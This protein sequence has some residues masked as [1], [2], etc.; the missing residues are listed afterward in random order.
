MGEVK[1]YEREKL[2]M[3]IMY[4]DRRMYDRAAETLCGI[5]GIIDCTSEEYSFSEFS[6]FYDI[7][8]NGDVM[9]RFVSFE[10]PVDPSLI[11]DIKIQTNSI[12]RDFSHEGRRRVNLD[13]CMLSHG[14][15][16]MATTK[17]ASFRIPLKGGI[18]ADLS[19][20]YSRGDWV[21]FFW[22]YFDVKSNKVKKFLKKARNIY[23]EQRKNGFTACTYD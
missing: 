12:E 13:P 9:K 14:K 2:V 7:E 1:T 19:L 11:S 6:R 15:F 8:M 17:S 3:G 22:T 16:V 4:T 20:V 23:L 5:Y 21:D 10:K 18:Y